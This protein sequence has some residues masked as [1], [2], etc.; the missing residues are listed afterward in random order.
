MGKR[1]RTEG[2]LSLTR[3]TGEIIE[4]Q[5]KGR[6]VGFVEVVS[7]DLKR[8]SATLLITGLAQVKLTLGQRQTMPAYSIELEEVSEVSRPFVRLRCRADKS[9]LI[10]R[11]ELCKS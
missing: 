1:I 2:G 11:G 10:L 6:K 7:I 3:R 9:I 8:R 4:F 5:R